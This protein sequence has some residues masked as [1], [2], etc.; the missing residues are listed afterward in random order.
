MKNNECDI[1]YCCCN[2]NQIQWLVTHGLNGES[3]SNNN[4]EKKQKKKDNV[5]NI[6]EYIS[7]FRP[8]GSYYRNVIS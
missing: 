3:T 2:K 4:K 6:N 7:C 8:F 1:C 5:R